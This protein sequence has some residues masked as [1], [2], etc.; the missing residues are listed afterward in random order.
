[1]SY[2]NAVACIAVLQDEYVRVS[3]PMVSGKFGVQAYS[4]E[5]HGTQAC[6]CDAHRHVRQYALVLEERYCFLN[7]PVPINNLHTLIDLDS[8]L[9]KV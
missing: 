3:T 9:Q 7:S 2:G 5:P 4:R 8:H 1:M 6:H